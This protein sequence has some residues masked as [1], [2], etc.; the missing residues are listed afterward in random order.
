LVDVEV[1]DAEYAEHEE[2]EV[3]KGLDVYGKSRFFFFFS[4]Q[5]SH[6]NQK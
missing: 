2:H 3:V 5:T 6:A 4:Q 1:W